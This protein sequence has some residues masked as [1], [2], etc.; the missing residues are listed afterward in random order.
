MDWWHIVISAATSV[1]NKVSDA[2]SVAGRLRV[3][4][5]VAQLPVFP[6]FTV[7]WWQVGLLQNRHS[8]DDNEHQHNL[9]LVTIVAV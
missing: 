7:W 8:T 1:D 5:E 3:L 6:A 9:N 4:I 2:F